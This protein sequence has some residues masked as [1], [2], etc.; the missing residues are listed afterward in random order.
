[1]GFRQGGRP[2]WRPEGTLLGSPRINELAARD[3]GDRVIWTKESLYQGVEYESEADL[4]SAI[5]EVQ[6][7]LF[8]KNRI[9]IDVK[10]KIGTKGNKQNIPDGYLIDLSGPMPRLYVVENEL[11]AHDPLRHVAVQ[12]LAR[13]STS[14]RRA[15]LRGFS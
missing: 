13:S 8:G 11:A 3:G 14:N 6:R 9:Y 12:I 10:R 4:E 2:H 5:R 7:D 15:E 1:M